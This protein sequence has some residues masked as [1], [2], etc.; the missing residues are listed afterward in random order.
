[1]LF[2]FHLSEKKSAST[3]QSAFSPPCSYSQQDANHILHPEAI[4]DIYQKSHNLVTCN[5]KIS[6]GVSSLTSW[7]PQV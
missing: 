5:R 4:V 3:C 6:V 7:P 2:N 1:M